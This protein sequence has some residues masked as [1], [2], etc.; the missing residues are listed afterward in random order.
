[1]STSAERMRLHRYRRENGLRCITLEI[2][3][4][5]IFALVRN[6]F[7]AP[8]EHKSDIA[9]KKALSRF[10]QCLLSDGLTYKIHPASR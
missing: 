3:E 2:R 5:D 7:L 4:K 6:G 10:L 9:I 1:M 8:H